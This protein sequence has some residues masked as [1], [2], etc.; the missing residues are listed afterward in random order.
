MFNPSYRPAFQSGQEPMDIGNV[1]TKQ[2]YCEKAMQNK[3][4]ARE[5][6]NQ[7][8]KD[9]SILLVWYTTKKATG[10]RNKKMRG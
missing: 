3:P 6:N 7:K 2:H 1:K 9:M 8:R 4:S 5:T 10:S